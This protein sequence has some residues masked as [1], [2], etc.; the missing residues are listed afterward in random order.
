MKERKG[1]NGLW[2]NHELL[3]ARAFVSRVSA[4][5]ISLPSLRRAIVELLYPWAGLSEESGREGSIGWD[6]VA[7][8]TVHYNLVYQ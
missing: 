7:H 8:T 3:G 4:L 5:F 1:T 2:P 6:L